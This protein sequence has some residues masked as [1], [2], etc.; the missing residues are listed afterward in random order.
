MLHM[1]QA[2]C[3]HEQKCLVNASVLF[4]LLRKY[5]YFIFSVLLYVL[6]CEKNNYTRFIAVLYIV[7]CELKLF[8]HAVEVIK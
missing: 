4:S 5:I 8:H 7:S 1:E 3:L 6:I 2:I